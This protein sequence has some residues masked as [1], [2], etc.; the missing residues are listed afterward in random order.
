MLWKVLEYSKHYGKYFVGL[1]C[2]EVRSLPQRS[3]GSPSQRHYRF[4]VTSCGYRCRVNHRLYS[5]ISPLLSCT[6][7][8]AYHDAHH[9][10]IR[11]LLI[12][13]TRTRTMPLF[14]PIA[15]PL[16]SV[17]PDYYAPARGC[18]VVLPL[19]FHRPSPL[20]F[21]VLPVVPILPPVLPSQ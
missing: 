6:V 1:E 17:I 7:V 20:P 19:A 4:V 12:S 8:S 3:G 10:Y 5:N 15:V 16:C 18:P 14:S 21:P 11:H 9:R 2:G 13:R